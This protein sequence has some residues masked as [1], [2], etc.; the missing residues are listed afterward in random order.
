M[1]GAVVVLAG[2]TGGAKLA[3]G[4]LDVVG[5]KRLVVVTNTGDDIEIHGGYVSPDADLVSFWLADLID[6]RGWGLRGDTFNVMDGL[7]ELGNEVWFS[8]GDR[9]LALALTRQRELEAG[10]RPTEV[11]QTLLQALGVDASVLPMSD[12]PVRTK[13]MAGG[14]WRSI[15]EYLICA[16][17]NDRWEPVQD[18]AF[19]GVELARATPEVLTAVAEADAILIGPSNPV[20][21]IGPILALH[22]L[23]A[24]IDASPAAVIAVS[25]I[26]SGEVLKGP[27]AEFM[28]SRG[29]PLSANSIAQ[30][31]DGIIDGLVS[32][33]PAESVPTLVTDLRMAEAASRRR[34]AA[35]TLG[36]AEAVH[37]AGADTK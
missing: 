27:T 21:S 16:R 23:R 12:Q 20:I 3:R 13:V 5:P 8:L 19:R 37:L 33:E 24:A 1:S 29:L 17:H 36:F 18:V 9:D 11:H 32:D 6:E 28:R 26:V 31:Y 22:D 15:Q 35:E 7:R 25:P 30:L 14:R 34:L 2:G 4:A 10:A